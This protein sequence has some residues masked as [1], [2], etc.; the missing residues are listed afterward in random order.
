M[1]SL[2]H[3]LFIGQFLHFQPHYVG[4]RV[5]FFR[6]DYSRYVCRYIGQEIIHRKVPSKNNIISQKWKELLS[7]SYLIKKVGTIIGSST[8]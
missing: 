8:K 6:P 5:I 3:T 7:K 4:M 2:G 1:Q